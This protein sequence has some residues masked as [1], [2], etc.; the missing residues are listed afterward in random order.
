M[1]YQIERDDFCKLMKECDPQDKIL[2]VFENWTICQTDTY[3]FI[4]N[5]E[6]VSIIDKDSLDKKHPRI[7][8]WYKLYHYGR[9]LNIP[10]LE[11]IKNYELRIEEVRWMLNHIVEEITLD[12]V[13]VYRYEK[14]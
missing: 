8:N 10:H 13:K 2:E 6:D 5:E 4:H 14:E 3:L 12:G 1:R 9:C 11:S 7:I